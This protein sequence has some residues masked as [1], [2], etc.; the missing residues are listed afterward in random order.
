LLTGNTGAD[1][2]Q[3]NLHALHEYVSQGGVLVIDADGGSKAFMASVQ[4]SLLPGA[5]PNIELAELPTSH[6]VLAGTG[7]CMDP[8]PKLRLRNYASLM[9]SG[10]PPGV[11]YAQFGKGMIFICPLDITTG[12]LDSGTYG[13]MG[14]TP[15]YSQSLMKNVILWALSRYRLQS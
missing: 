8:L 11:Q 1:F 9:I 12:L 6:P 14:Y 10:I 2:G 7:D 4:N 5:F 13:I 15:A 3:M